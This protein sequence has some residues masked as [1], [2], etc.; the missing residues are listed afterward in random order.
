M[1]QNSQKNASDKLREYTA[2]RKK[3][4]KRRR[5]AAVYLVLLLFVCIIC[6]ILSLTVFFN[7]SQI[8]VVGN[9][10]YTPEQIVTASGFETGDNLL[11]MD[12]AEM[13]ESILKTLPYVSDVRII[14]ELPSTVTIKVTET[15]PACFYEVGENRY[16]LLSDSLRVMEI[17][18]VEPETTARL[19]GIVM[20]IPDEGE[21]ASAETDI[22]EKILLDLLTILREND[23]IITNNITFTNAINVSFG[24]ADRVTVK[25]GGN[26]DL[27][28]K[29]GMVKAY[30]NDCL[31]SVG[32]WTIDVSS[33]DKLYAGR[34]QEKPPEEESSESGDASENSG[35]DEDE[36]GEKDSGESKNDSE[37]SSEKSKKKDAEDE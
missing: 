32:E 26:S 24:T 19:S 34:T 22:S 20:T 12:K 37:S 28:Y 13:T 14:R 16:A 7:A 4:Y 10:R 17:V 35:S 21:I 31:P 27:E 18:N 11:R 25:L 15:A 3:K 5:K 30:L 36:D 33:G 8:K 1:K 23:I 2:R 29:I 9:S 6:L